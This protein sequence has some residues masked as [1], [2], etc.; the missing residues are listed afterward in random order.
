MSSKIE[1]IRAMLKTRPITSRG[2]SIEAMRFNLDAMGDILIGDSSVTSKAELIDTISSQW[3]Y[4][5]KIRN[6][7]VLLYF[8]GGGY[9]LGSIKSHRALLERLATATE[10][11]VLAVD[12]RLAPE[13]TFP[14]ALNDALYAYRWLLKE[15]VKPR[16]IVIGETPLAE[17]SR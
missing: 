14:A 5:R 4:S 8:H 15:G 17:D 6:D 1:T 13:N 10:G 11:S 7:S 3:F 2:A 16:H 9:L 12:Y